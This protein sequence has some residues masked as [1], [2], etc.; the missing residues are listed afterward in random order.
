MD[1]LTK[2]LNDTYDD[3]YE[4][5]EAEI[6]MQIANARISGKPCVLREYLRT[7]FVSRSKYDIA[8]DALS[9]IAMNVKLPIA[10]ARRALK[11]I[12]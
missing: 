2:V 3:V 1:K 11:E 4:K 6:F 9:A 8:R 5:A 10:L 7:M 12:Q